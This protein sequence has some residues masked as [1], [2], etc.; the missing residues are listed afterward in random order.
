MIAALTEAKRQVAEL[1]KDYTGLDNP[2]HWR[3]VGLPRSGSFGSNGQYQYLF[4]GIGCRFQL[5]DREID[6]D[7]GHDGRVDGFNMWWLRCFAEDSTD[8]FPEFRDEQLLRTCFEEACKIGQIGQ[9]YK[10]AQ[11][12]LFYVIGQTENDSCLA[13]PSKG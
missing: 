1:F 10:S 2:M 8:V 3:Q 6:F 4:H 12:D 11:D 13:Y 5:V 9:L 7:F